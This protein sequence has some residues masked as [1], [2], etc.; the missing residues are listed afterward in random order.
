MKYALVTAP[1]AALLLGASIV[2]SVASLKTSGSQKPPAHGN[3]E[4]TS[5]GGG[6]KNVVFGLAA[7]GSKVA[8][9][10]QGVD[11][12]VHFLE[13][14]NASST[15]SDPP[16]C[17]EFIASCLQHV[18]ALVARIDHSYTDVQ[19]Q[20]VLEN[21]CWL[22]KRFPNVTEDGFEDEKS[23]QEFAKKLTTA[24]H[25]ELADG[26]QTGYG[27]FCNSYYVHLGGDCF[28][29]AVATPTKPEPKKAD[30]GSGLWWKISLIVLAV[31]GLVAIGLYAARRLRQRGNESG[32]A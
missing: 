16:G 18:K 6:V 21:E 20:S 7:Q 14:T 29:G 15:N 31:V 9:V 2:G 12:L 1:W 24:R 26:A 3:M 17:D 5:A 10:R 8:A 32:Q 23:C 19:L 27:S 28:H 30:E 25:Q 11:D 13:A 22:E 4:A